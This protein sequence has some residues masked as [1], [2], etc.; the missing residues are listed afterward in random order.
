MQ[1]LDEAAIIVGVG[2]SLSGL[3]EGGARGEGFPR[4]ADL[5][6]EGVE[7]EGDTVEAIEGDVEGQGGDK[8]RGR[9]G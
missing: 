9:H 7:V 6:E 1:G 3:E 2:E 4:A 8:V 5:L